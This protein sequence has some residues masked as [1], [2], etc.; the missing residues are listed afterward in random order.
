MLKLT[1]N[2]MN[3]LKNRYFIEGEDWKGMWD[4]IFNHIVPIGEPF[5]KEMLNACLNGDI[6]PNTPVMTNAGIDN[7]TTLSA[8]TYNGAVED[9]LDGFNK[10][11]N[12]IAQSTS[13]GLGCGLNFSYLRPKMSMVKGHKNLACG[14]VGFL[15][16]CNKYIEILKQ[17]KRNG[18]V[19][20]IL[21][22]DHPEVLDFM[23]VKSLD[24]NNITNANLSIMYNKDFFDNLEKN[25]NKKVILRFENDVIKNEIEIDLT[26]Q[27]F[28]YKH[29]EFAWKCG[30][31][32]ILFQDNM[33]KNIPK[34]LFE[35]FGKFEG[36]NLCGEQVLFKDQICNLV[37]VNLKNMLN[38]DFKK[39]KFGWNKFKTTLEFA[40][41]FGDLVVEKFQLPLENQVKMAKLT[42]NIGIGVGGLADIFVELNIKYGSDESFK[43]AEELASKWE[44]HTIDY[45][46]ILGKEKGLPEI[47][48]NNQRN[49]VIQVIAPM[50]GTGLIAGINGGIEPY[51]SIKYEREDHK[52]KK[53]LYDIKSDMINQNDEVYV[54]AN[55]V[56]PYQ[57][58]KMQSIFQKHCDASISKTVN[59]PN[60]AT[61]KDVYDSYLLAYKLGCKGTTVYRDGSKKFQ[62]LTSDET[63]SSQLEKFYDIWKDHKDGIIKE[64]VKLPK[65]FPMYGYSLESEGKKWYILIAFKDEGLKRPFALFIKTKYIEDNID[66]EKIIDSLTNLAKL[67]GIPEKFILKNEKEYALKIKKQYKKQS[68]TDKIAC[69]FSLLLRHNVQIQ[70]I[71]E[72][73]DN[74]K[75]LSISSLVVRIKKFLTSYIQKGTKAK[76]KCKFCG[77]ESLAYQSSCVTCLSCGA[78][79]C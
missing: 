37:H 17:N 43:F 64:H 57:H 8:C 12:S 39:A 68:N 24:D 3:L 55:D 25:P 10:A 69:L 36:T 62:V 33:N 65:E 46:I 6:I 21:R 70:D 40:V 26:Y 22:W 41:R 15:Q 19:M 73:L 5:R 28:F 32:G 2:A 54:G 56:T 38:F 72:T 66:A 51:F 23:E 75:D 13:A 58:I 29:S 49:T 31:P 7:R 1:T 74:I 59:L 9:S 35:R 34:V 78:S 4:R 71:V 76:G 27:E 67:K 77:Q 52:G 18:G 44:K 30:D 45:S 50:G 61:I 42:R 60:S 14:V 48:V 79:K 11:L 16:I 63:K 53:Y 47:N 20:A